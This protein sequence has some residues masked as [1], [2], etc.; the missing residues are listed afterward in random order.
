MS[1]LS[2]W[3]LFKFSV[4]SSWKMKDILLFSMLHFLINCQILFIKKKSIGEG[5]KKKR[6]WKC[7]ESGQEDLQNPNQKIDHTWQCWGVAAEEIHRFSW[8]ESNKYVLNINCIFFP[9]K[10]TSQVYAS[11][12]LMV[13]FLSLLVLPPAFILPILCVCLVAQSCREL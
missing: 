12:F 13:L 10:Q 3:C 8:W 1:K 11:L 2:R 7:T 4:L 5:E 6:T 9:P